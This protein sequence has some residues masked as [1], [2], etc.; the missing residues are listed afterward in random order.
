MGGQGRVHV[1]ESVSVGLRR[2][3][4]QVGICFTKLVLRSIWTEDVKEMQGEK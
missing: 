3:C 2:T 1:G 4:G